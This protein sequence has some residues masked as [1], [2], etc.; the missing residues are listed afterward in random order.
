MATSPVSL[1]ELLPNDLKNIFDSDLEGDD[2][3]EVVDMRT[4]PLSMTV[5]PPDDVFISETEPESDNEVAIVSFRLAAGPSVSTM[6]L[7]HDDADVSET[8]PETDEEDT[9]V[10]SIQSLFYC[11]TVSHRRQTKQVDAGQRAGV[12][13]IKHVDVGQRA[14]V[15]RIKRE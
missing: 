14:R 15:K 1:R 3:V 9:I 10:S 2:N 4:A 13:C 7:S 12:K 6:A 5:Q 11:R 8:E